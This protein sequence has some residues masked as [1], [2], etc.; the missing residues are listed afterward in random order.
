MYELKGY[1]AERLIKEFP[2]KGWKLRALNKLLRKLKDTGTT[3]RRPGSGRPRSALTASSINTVNDLVLSQEDVPRSHRTTCQIHRETGISQ[4]SVM[5]IIHDDLQLK[6]LK[7]RRA[8]ELTAANRLA[9]LSRSKQLLRKFRRQRL[10]IFF[11]DEKVFTVT[12][13]VN[14][15]NNGVYAPITIKKCDVTAERLLRTRSTFS[16]SVMVSLAASK[17]GCTDLIFVEPG[18]K[19]SR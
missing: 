1:G 13:P 5:R 14:P 3:D 19:D 16:K 11:T 8:Q 9:R 17:L 7:R 2:T 18:V 4:T 15:Q 6:C 12:P 10:T